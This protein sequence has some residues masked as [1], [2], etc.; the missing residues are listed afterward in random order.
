[1]NDDV[2]NLLHALVASGQEIGLQVAAYIDGQLVVD[3]WAGLAD[4]A[5]GRPV[6]GET[7]FTSWS[8]TKGFAATCVHIL[9]ERGLIDYDAPIAHYWPAFSAHG[10][11][12]ATV[13]HALTHAAGV[14]QLPPQT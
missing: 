12:A 5:T 3:T 9:A 11:G 8:T 6:D 10:K 13:R 2:H 1:M 7:L 4:P 14:P